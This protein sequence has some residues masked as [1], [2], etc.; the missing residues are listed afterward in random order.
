VDAWRQA[1]KPQPLALVWYKDD[2]VARVAITPADGSGDRSSYTDYCYRLDGSL[3]RVRSVPQ[4]R[5]IVI[6]LFF[7]AVTRFA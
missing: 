3:A 1:G 5:P 2:R 4:G 6:S 7:I